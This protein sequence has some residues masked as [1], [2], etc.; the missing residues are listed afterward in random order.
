MKKISQQAV[1]GTPFPSE[2][3]LTEQRRIVAYLDGVQAKVQALKHLQAE[4]AAQLD[5]LMPAV[6][7]RAFRGGL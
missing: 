3:A 4:S 1:M 5:A 2:V 6:L 7:E